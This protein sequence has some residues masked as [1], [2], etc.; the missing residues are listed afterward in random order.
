[1]KKIFSIFL[2]LLMLV[3]SFG[4]FAVFGESG[5][6]VR[7]A[8]NYP[9]IESEVEGAIYT[10][11]FFLS[12]SVFDYSFVVTLPDGREVPLQ[13]EGTEDESKALTKYRCYGYAYI[14]FDEYK[15]VKK[16]NSV[17]VPVHI[18]VSLSEINDYGT[19]Y[20]KATEY[21]T[22]IY[23]PLVGNYI[24]SITTIENINAYVYDNS[25]TAF[26]DD[27]VFRVEY[28]D[29][30]EKE[31]TP[32]ITG[33]DNRYHYTLDGNN[34]AYDVN[35]DMNKVYV[36][37]FDATCSYDLEEIRAFPFSSIRFVGCRLDGDM[38]TEVIYEV[39]YK[40]NN[41]VVKYAKQVT[42]YSGYLDMLEGFP[43]T[44][45]TEGSKYTSTVEVQLGTLKDSKSYELQQQGLLQRI[46][47]KIVW[48]FK[49][50]FAAGIF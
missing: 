29:G 18:S 26:L 48:F 28:W 45:S 20:N 9:V 5:V 3:S 14:D 16:E 13:S 10:S 37:Y 19:G 31:F 38:P 46:I 49:Q 8:D 27:T 41:R 34:L 39:T 40:D 1:M 32:V 6:T 35:R 11:V 43:V 17:A 25:E 2:A 22:V 42:G 15:K 30:S 4:C 12:S 33:Y 21:N 50:I 47:G 7:C 23:K 24:K 36:S 44:Y